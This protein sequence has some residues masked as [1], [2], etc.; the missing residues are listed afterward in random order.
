MYSNLLL[1]IQNS[2][3]PIISCLY[4]IVTASGLEIASATDMTLC[5]KNTKFCI[6]G[7]N[8]GVNACKPATTF[9][10]SLNF[11]S[12]KIGLEMLLTG[13]ETMIDSNIA[14]NKGFI[15]Y[16]GNDYDDM[17]NIAL[18]YANIISN[19]SK[20][21]ISIVVAKWIKLKAYNVIMS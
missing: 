16:I 3:L 9:S 21:C 10:N 4:G 14:Y 19:K 13:K 17:N 11:N 15:N 7:I 6:P 20:L 12:Y 2:R 1:S 8:I 18:K 5:S